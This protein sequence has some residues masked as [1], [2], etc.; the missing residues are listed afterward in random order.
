MRC[1]QAKRLMQKALAGGATAAEE[2]RLADHAEACAKCAAQWTAMTALAQRLRAAQPQELR[3]ERDLA[4]EALQRVG[5]EA[6]VEV[7]TPPAP[8]WTGRLF[9][10]RLAQAAGAVVFMAVC[11]A[12]LMATRPSVGVLGGGMQTMS[13]LLAP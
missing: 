7:W 3:T 6:G 2:Q 10:S 13:V 1:P 11:I 8:S 9:G 5:L 12:L 4:R